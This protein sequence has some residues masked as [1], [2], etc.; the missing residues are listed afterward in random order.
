[1]AA[2]ANGPTLAPRTETI[3]SVVLSFTGAG[4]QAWRGCRVRVWHRDAPLATA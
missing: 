2:T 3:N 1:M 4:K